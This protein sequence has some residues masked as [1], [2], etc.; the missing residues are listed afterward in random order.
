ME[1]KRKT[2]YLESIFIGTDIISTRVI[3]LNV[4][5]SK[6]SSVIAKKQSNKRDQWLKSSEE[7]SKKE[8]VF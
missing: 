1:G 2:K 5:Y 4:Q 3:K 6:E 8:R 7:L